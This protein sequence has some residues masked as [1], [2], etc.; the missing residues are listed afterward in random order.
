MELKNLTGLLV[1]LIVTVLLFATI[2]LPV[3]NSASHTEHTIEDGFDYYAT[4]KLG[5]YT[6]EF[7]SDGITFNGT[8]LGNYTVTMISDCWK[9][10]WY[11][12][13]ATLYDITAGQTN[14]TKMVIGA[15]GSYTYTASDVDTTSSNTL[16]KFVGVCD[17]G[18]YVANG[19][20]ASRTFVVDKNATVYI[21]PVSSLSGTLNSGKYITFIE[22]TY[23]D[24]TMSTC[25]YYADSTWNE[26]TGTASIN[27]PVDNGDGTVTIDHKADVVI[28]TYSNANCTYGLFIPV[29]YHTENQGAEY[30]LIGIIPLL[31]CVGIILAV[32]QIFV[33]RE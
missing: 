11:N 33:R 27:G 13:T 15:D 22:G 25:Y 20:D 8:L 2:V 14:I 5:D 12:N 30:D 28:E 6:Y 4:D 26:G 31:I 16:T 17:V 3:I 1:G 24:L 9:L 32:A 7:S 23:D 19:S 21:N 18:D 29:K 10:Q